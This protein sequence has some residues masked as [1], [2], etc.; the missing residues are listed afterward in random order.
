MPS[1]FRFTP[2]NP[3]KMVGNRMPVAKS[4][5]EFKFMQRL[6]TLLN[7]AAWTYEPKH[8]GVYY[9]CPIDGN[10]KQYIP[11]FLVQ[12]TN[13]Q[14]ELIEIKPMQFAHERAAKSLLQKIELARNIAKW[15]SATKTAQQI[16]AK[17]IVLTEKQLFP[18]KPKI[19]KP[20]KVTK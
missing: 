12:Y 15:D 3:A 6:D 16:G 10:T 19:A 13:G 4:S 7:V 14:V 1:S 5:W 17:F 2:K 20:N 11:D 8:L 9:K 18:K